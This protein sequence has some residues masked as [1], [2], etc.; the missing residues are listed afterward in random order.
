MNIE[1]RLQ[2]DAE[3]LDR[4]MA[5][6]DPDEFMRNLRT[7]L[8]VP[9]SDKHENCGD[10]P[11]AGRLTAAGPAGS[12]PVAKAIAMQSTSMALAIVRGIAANRN[13]ANGK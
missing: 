1:Q 7:R 6:H 12:P 10:A 3:N 8:G 5:D 13:A 2:R 9:S 11:S 4:L